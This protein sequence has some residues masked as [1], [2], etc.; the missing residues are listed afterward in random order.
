MNGENDVAHA[1]ASELLSLISDSPLF[2]CETIFRSHF[3][4]RGGRPALKVYV[5]FLGGIGRVRAGCG[6]Q[7]PRLTPLCMLTY[8]LIY[9]KTLSLPHDH[10]PRDD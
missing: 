8:L 4:P 9:L 6:D 3:D 7:L 10:R 2:C 5:S 1:Q